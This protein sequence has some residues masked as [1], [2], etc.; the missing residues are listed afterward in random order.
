M[1]YLGFFVIE[2]FYEVVYDGNLQKG[3]WVV[4]LSWVYDIVQEDFVIVV[5]D[6]G[7]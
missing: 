1:S 6:Y 3:L 7:V 2:D 5:D 4:L